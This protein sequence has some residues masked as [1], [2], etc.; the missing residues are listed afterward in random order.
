MK[1]LFI[2]GC[3]LF[4]LPDSTFVFAQQALQQSTV[5]KEKRQQQK[6]E[7][8]FDGASTK[9]KFVIQPALNFGHH[10]GLGNINY[11]SA[12]YGSGLVPGVTLN[13]DYNVHHYVSIGVYYAAAFRNYKT[14]D[15]FYLA[16]VFGARTAFHWW[17]LLDD[18]LDADLFSN[19]LDIDVHAHLGAY[20]LTLNDRAIAYKYKTKGFNAGGGIALRYYFVEHFGVAM[21]FGYE[22]ASWA[23]L[24]FAIKI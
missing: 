19:K 15:V 12:S 23:K 17:Q 3:L 1:K 16:H 14:A 13:L 22:E 5:K 11:G 4:L 10:L 21:E 7:H 9:G 8:T 2:L 18:K 6:T 20:L 24:G